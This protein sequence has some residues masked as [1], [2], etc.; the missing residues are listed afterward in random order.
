MLAVQ[1]VLMVLLS[2]LKFKISKNRDMHVHLK[3]SS[4]LVTYLCVN[5]QE[6]LVF[7]LDFSVV[8]ILH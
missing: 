3:L 5:C 4:V 2:T 1:A 7:I 8:E 6:V